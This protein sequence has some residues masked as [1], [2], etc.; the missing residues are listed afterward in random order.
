ML[1]LAA[2][3]GA[4]EG[5]ISL[6]GLTHEEWVIIIWTWIAMA[7]IITLA[8]I[9]R[10]G[11]KTIPT[12]MAGLFEHI[13][14]WIDGLAHGMMGQTGRN[15][16][17]LA[18]TIFL[19]VLVSNWM[20]LLPGFG[21]IKGNPES[22][23]GISFVTSNRQEAAETVKTEKAP[24]PAAPL[25]DL[26][27]APTS[28]INTTLALAMIS[29][30]SFNLFG[31]RKHYEHASTAGPGHEPHATVP[32]EAGEEREP[33][34]TV[35]LDDAPPNALIK[36]FLSWLGH[37]VQPTPML[38]HSMEGVMRYLLVPPMCLLFIVL[39]IVEELARIIS[40]TLRL[41][42]N[43][44][45][46]HQVKIGLVTVMFVFGGTAL[47]SLGSNILGATSNGV[48]T[49][50]VFG[51]SVFVTLIGALAGFVQA[52]VFTLLTISYISHAVVLEH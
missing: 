49:L 36:G 1:F 2:A 21:A 52:M 30:L 22:S 10:S 51:I 37:F 14:D 5:L 41:F 47:S 6:H 18:M 13:Y 40:L 28:N 38:W 16:V 17:P 25:L 46:E 35:P 7:L 3:E 43:I 34:D 29:F 27:E 20:G 8:V 11:L 44:A 26:L 9:A 50:L 19:L 23:F 31:M 15:Y 39:N 12:A 32:H 33:H 24:T 48:L 45:G 4:S 42:G